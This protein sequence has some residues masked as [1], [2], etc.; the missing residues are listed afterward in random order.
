MSYQFTKTVRR[1]TQNDEMTK[2]NTSYKMLSQREISKAHPNLFYND[3]RHKIPILSALLINI[4]G[5]TDQLLKKLGK[6]KIKTIF[7][8]DETI[9]NILPDRNIKIE[10]RKEHMNSNVIRSS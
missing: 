1:T 8:Y 2:L 7:T 4:K 6:Y 10:I 3:M 5:T 9:E